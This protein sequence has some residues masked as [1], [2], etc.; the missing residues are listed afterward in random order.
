MS[1]AQMPVIGEENEVLNT[2]MDHQY[3]LHWDYYGPMAEGT[4]EHF[5]RHLLQFLKNH[6]IEG[7]ETGIQIHSATHSDAWCA[8][9]GDAFEF[10]QPKLRP[11]RWDRLDSST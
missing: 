6:N 8:V 11:H 7:A 5:Q 1:S 2:M 10:I 3:C 9:D 4:A